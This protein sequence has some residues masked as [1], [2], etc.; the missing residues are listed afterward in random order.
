[1]VQNFNYHTHTYRC[2]HAYGTDEE[3]IEAAIQAGYK[4][5]GFSDH[6]PYRDYPSDFSHMDWDQLDEYIE[7]INI[8][9]EKYKGIIDIKLG[10]ETEYYSDNHDERFELK[11]RMEYLLLG[12]HYAS[13]E[14]GHINFFKDNTDEEIMIYG[15][16][17]CTALDT[18]MFLYL[19]HPDVFLSRQTQFTKAC[20]DVAHMIAKK[21]VET[22]TPVELNVRGILKGR[23]QFTSGQYYYYPHRDFWKILSQYPLRY[24]IGID[25]HR[26]EE[27]LDKKVIDMAL[28]EVSDFNLNFIKEPLL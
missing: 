15:Q 22:D 13:P 20:E 2:K 25:A 12:Q 16:R 18:G 19:C 1:M 9:K 23:H 11:N 5:L 6:A 21:C 27:L 24:L 14:K 3:F 4:T 17:V 10:L 7:S 8:L 28:Q 26:P